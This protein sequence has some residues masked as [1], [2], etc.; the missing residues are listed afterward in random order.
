M[1]SLILQTRY[2]QSLYD[3]AK[4][5]NQIE[6][7]FQDMLLIEQICQ[8]NRLL[9]AILKN[10]TIKPLKKRS[11]LKEVFAEKLSPVTIEFL[12]LLSAKR[13]D[14]YLLEI[15]QRYIAIY[16]KEKGIKIAYLTV[17][18]K[19]SE[20]IRDQLTVLLKQELESEIEIVEKI[21][22]KLIGGFSLAIE[23]NLYDASLLKGI[24]TLRQDFSKNIYEGSI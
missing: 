5:L 15:S 8:E 23:G 14:V 17:A 1:S 6:Q 20:D 2:A 7:V 11:I 22:P 18:E 13:R 10:P 21:D 12:K 24:T 16:K 9:R 3:L 19:T 4:K